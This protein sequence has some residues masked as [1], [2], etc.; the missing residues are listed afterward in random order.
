MEI[1]INKRICRILHMF[2]TSAKALNST[3][4]NLMHWNPLRFPDMLEQLTQ[5]SRVCFFVSLTDIKRPSQGI[6][7]WFGEE[8]EVSRPVLILYTVS[9]SILVCGLQ[10]V[11]P[12]WFL[13]TH[14]SLEFHNEY[15]TRVTK[16]WWCKGRE[17]NQANKM[18]KD[19]ALLFPP[20]SM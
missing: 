5:A 11:A 8:K 7:D 4:R 20:P 12:A 15:L 18:V 9:Y 1:W 13:E 2:K 6:R 16:V 19:H 3:E 14:R 10:L 17:D